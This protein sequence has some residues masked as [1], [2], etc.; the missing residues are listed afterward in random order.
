MNDEKI[1][2]LFSINFL[3]LIAERAG[4]VVTK[5]SEDYGD[6]LIIKE[7]KVSLHFGSR[8]IYTSGKMVGLQAKCTT[9]KSI[10][11]SKGKF[12]F[13]LDAKPFNH[14]VLRRD[15]WSLEKLPPLV[16]V[17][18][19]LPENPS[20]WLSHDA[21]SGKLTLSGKGY[22][23]LPETNAELTKNQDRERIFLSE[24]NQVDLNFYQ[25]MISLHF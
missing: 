21:K 3:R 13:D 5:P 6:D 20:D 9:E 4:F 8:Q 15:T 12:A 18:F 23:Y 19:V 1:K 16:L 14:L 2:E 24:E 7:L 22:W 17:V 11:R 10:R 25:E